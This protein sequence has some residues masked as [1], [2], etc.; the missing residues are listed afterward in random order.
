VLIQFLDWHYV[1]KELVAKDG[2]TDWEDFL[3][4]VEAVQLDQAAAIECLTRHGLKR[5]LVEGLTEANMPAL[6]D[7]VAQLLKRSSISLP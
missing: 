2:Q 5:V 7:K 4:E 6:P 1:D 3:L